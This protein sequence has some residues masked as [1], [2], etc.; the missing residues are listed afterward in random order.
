MKTATLTTTSGHTW[1]TSINGTRAEI[2]EYFLGKF[3]NIGVYDDTRAD[4]GE[5]M[6]QVVS[7]IIPA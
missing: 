2:R 4:E 6:E 3:F 5:K 7:V 1:K